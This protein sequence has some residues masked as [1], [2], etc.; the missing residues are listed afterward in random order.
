MTIESIADGVTHAITIV[1]SLR[2]V[3][4]KNKDAEVVDLLSDLSRTLSDV[5]LQLADSKTE[6]EDLKSKIFEL[7]KG[8]I[9]LRNRLI[10]IQT[11]KD[12][13]P[14]N[15]WQASP[16]REKIL[17]M[18]L[19]MSQ[20]EEPR[21]KIRQVADAVDVNVREAKKLTSEMEA[22]NLIYTHYHMA[23]PTAYTITDDGRRALIEENLNE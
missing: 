3:A 15:Q 12:E 5:R 4:T 11:T 10:N 18:L 13:S 19:Y 6:N 16:Q 9:F 21:L 23:Y 17:K 8:T 22:W 7:N 14:S 2:E 20:S 1:E